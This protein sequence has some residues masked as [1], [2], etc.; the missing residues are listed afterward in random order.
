MLSEEQFPSMVA[1]MLALCNF[2]KAEEAITEVTSNHLESWI[3]PSKTQRGLSLSDIA[4][5]EGDVR[6]VMKYKVCFWIWYI[7]KIENSDLH[8][9]MGSAFLNMDLSQVL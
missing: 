2:P 5:F 8:W 1:T 4:L 7:W 3:Y 9:A 6:L